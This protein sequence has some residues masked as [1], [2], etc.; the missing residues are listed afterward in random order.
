MRS[1]RIIT[2][3]GFVALLSL[4]SCGSGG[5]S[6]SPTTTTRA[7][8]SA[9]ST[10]PAS[11]ATTAMNG[12]TSAPNHSKAA[13][14]GWPGAHGCDKPSAADVG[15]AFGTPITKSVPASDSGC[16][17]ETDTPGRGVQ[18][19]YHTPDQDPFNPVELNMFHSTGTVTDLAIPG[20]TQAFIRDIA[21]PQVDNP[22]AYVVYPEGAVQVSMSGA[23]GSLVQ[24]NLESTV[25][26]IVG[27]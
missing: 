9:T 17:W 21:V 27:A 10:A 2:V 6:A 22:I 3:V 25:K 26:L 24:S 13:N 14:G 4:A 20:A 15:T 23:P 5:S 8:G 7:G 16:L 1:H 12:S 18:V 11:T 19:S